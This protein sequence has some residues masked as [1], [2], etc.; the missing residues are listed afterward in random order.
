MLLTVGVWLFYAI[1]LLMR[2]FPLR[3]ESMGCQKQF[4]RNYRPTECTSAKK[5]AEPAKTGNSIPRNFPWRKVDSWRT[6]AAV[7]ASWLA[8]NALIGVAYLL[9]WIDRGIL[10]LISLAFSVCDVI[11]ILFFCPFQTWMMKNRCCTTCRIYNWDF[12]MMFTPLVWIPSVY[13]YTLL[14]G[15]LVLLLRWEITYRRHP[16]RFSEE[17]NASLNCANCKERLCAHKKQ[18]KSFWKKYR[19]K[20]QTNTKGDQ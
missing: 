20:L 18:L 3:V 1:A 4:A 8:L 9:G 19:N 15:A 13:T 14:G 12:A 5:G 2:F 17:T 10:M 16:E 6:T 11:C 7:A